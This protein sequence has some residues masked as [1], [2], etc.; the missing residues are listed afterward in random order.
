MGDAAQMQAVVR[1]RASC[2]YV[3][4][5]GPG[6]SSSTF[7]YRL[8]AAHPAFAAPAIKEDCYYRRHWRLE[9]PTLGPFANAVAAMVPLAVKRAVPG[10]AK[11]PL[12]RWLR[13][14]RA[15]CLRR[16]R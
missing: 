3:L 5:A 10:R 13:A 14:P 2:D 6:R 7:L 16:S 9:N 1:S 12:K 4:V 8:L 11:L 15:G